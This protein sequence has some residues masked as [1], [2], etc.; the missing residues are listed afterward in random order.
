MVRVSK[1]DFE[2]PGDVARWTSVEASDINL[3]WLEGEEGTSDVS[4]IYDEQYFAST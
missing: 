3:K 4:Y 1:C 2:I